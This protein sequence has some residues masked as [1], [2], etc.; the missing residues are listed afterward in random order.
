MF[1]NRKKK[2]EVSPEEASAEQIDEIRE[3]AETAE[4]PCP[5][6][7]GQSAATEM[8]D[9]VEQ[10]KQ[11]SNTAEEVA[12]EEPKQGFF[13]RLAGGMT[14]TRDKLAGNLSNL[15][16]ENEIDEDFYE[17]LEEILVMS[18]IGIRST[19]EILDRLKENV[20]KE[21]IKER[22]LCRELL[23]GSIREQMATSES[24][25][26]FEED[27]SVI[28]VVGVNGAGKTTTIGKLA[29]QFKNRGKKVLI[30]AADTFRA[31][32]GDQLS[33]WA[34]RAGVEMIGGKDGADPSSVIF[35]AAHR[36]QSRNIDIL[37]CD[38]AGRLQNKKNLMAELHKMGT[39]AQ[40]EYPGAH[41]EILLVL[42]ATTG[43]NALSQAREFN[44]VTELTG[45]I[46]TKMD[47]TAKGG[48]AIAIQSE[49]GVPVKYIGV[50]EK[51]YDLQRFDA[52]SFVRAM[53]EG[54]EA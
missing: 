6:A 44:E 32:A 33:A 13:A 39:I 17:E 24:D 4:V 30:A 2:Q 38:T 12:E 37:L 54:E 51:I 52:D 35:D 16:K 41:V 53:F 8:Q 50:G 48:I 42:D 31:A 5:V 9:A 40:K 15:F 43:Q 36:A 26:S 14:K 28:L 29:Y 47:G 20:K 23:I 18:D 49:L 25:F 21:H 22:A 27:K 7:E 11:A 1:W 3:E 45:I 46:L 34:S 19:E 10:E